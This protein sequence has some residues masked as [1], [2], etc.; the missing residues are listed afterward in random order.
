MSVS[1][2]IKKKHQELTDILRRHNHLYYV[3]D[4]PEIPDGEYDKLFQELLSLEEL[5]PELV[6]TDSPSQRVGGAP[7]DAFNKVKHSIPMLSLG[8]VFTD[9]E[10]DKFHARLK[11]QAEVEDIDYVAETKLDG[12][13]VSIRYEDGLLVQAAT[14]GDGKTGEDI[15]AN[16]RTIKAIPLRLQGQAPKVLEVRGEVFMSRSGFNK[17]NAEL[18]KRELK[19]FANP[20]NA[21]AGG[22]R[23]L[24]SRITAT[25]PLTMYCYAVGMVSDDADLPNTHWERLQWLKPFGFPISPLMRRVK[26]IDG[27]IAFYNEIQAQR[28]RLDYE[29]DGVVYKV[30]SITLQDDLGFVSRAPRW[31]TAHKFPAQEVLTTLES[32]DFQ[33]GR[34]GALTPVARL[35]P[36]E[37]GG[38]V[39]SNATLHN[40]DE[41]ERKDVRIGDTVVVRRAGDVIPEVV[42][43]VISQR[44]VNT[45]AISMPTECPVCHS[46]VIRLENE[47]VAR[48]TGAYKCAAQQKE[49]IKH[50]ASRK[51]M[52]IDGLGDKL[53][54]QLYDANLIKTPLDIFKLNVEQIAALERMGEKSASNLVNAIESA[55][56]TSFARF[57]FAL[58]IREVGETT[59]N[60]LAHEFK[61]IDA[62][63]KATI[64]ELLALNDIGPIMAEHIA[65]YFHNE[66]NLKLVDALLAT[67][68]QWENEGQEP[69]S[70]ALAGKT[71]VI[72]GTLSSMGRDEAKKALQA[73]GAKV[74]GSVS[75]NTDF[76][77]AGEKAGSKLTKAEKLGV[78]IMSDDEFIALLE[79]FT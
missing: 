10:L 76:L 66:E 29:I 50:F 41:I 7:L 19:T 17:M 2:S 36:V 73:L 75:K 74:T 26:N 42:N 14:R 56:Q 30:D 6:T 33:V 72:T 52:D 68:I 55:K 4:N 22:L 71:F 8:N 70:D 48:C 67:G 77:L 78:S 62:L 13:A 79:K 1:H 64:A 59:A 58:G 39:V 23:Q 47:A 43:P 54:E 25:R 37:V 24:D 12:L 69:L 51:A 31:A 53:V 61:D 28:D 32:V 3:L 57:L 49:G 60:N 20:R 63:K 5:H 34:T 38:V 44:P 11:K 21:A 35:K 40:M 65:R 46:A 15:T 27:L 16:V 9:E 45:Q 18:R